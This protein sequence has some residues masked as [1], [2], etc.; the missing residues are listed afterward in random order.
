MCNNCVSDKF[1]RYNYVRN[2]S[3]NDRYI[4]FIFPFNS[5]CNTDLIFIRT[6]FQ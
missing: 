6:Y 3:V 1:M 4:F 2:R 5:L